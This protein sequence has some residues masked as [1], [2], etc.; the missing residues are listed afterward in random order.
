MKIALNLTIKRKWFEMIRIGT[1]KEEYRSA[2]NR[3]VARLFNRCGIE[4]FPDG[5]V[6]IFRNG[7][8]LGSA[9]VAVELL[10]VGIRS[11]DEAIHPEWGEPTVRGTHFVI[12]LGKV[13]DVGAYCTVRDMITEM[14]NAD[15]T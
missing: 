10:M 12:R 6:A 2:D 11:G 5:L 8:N 9:A 7:Y 3:T 1:K 4:P 13:L 15:A 14:S